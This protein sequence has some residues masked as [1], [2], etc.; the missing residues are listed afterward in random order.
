MDGL[1]ADD[2][3]D[4]DE[5]AQREEA[6]ED[7]LLAGLNLRGHEDWEG[8]EHAGSWQV[9][10]QSGL[11]PCDCKRYRDLGKRR[12]TYTATSKTMVND[13]MLV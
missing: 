5:D 1:D 12:K 8:K 6:E 3:D 10:C 4:C 9:E 11:D 13:A 7:E 2:L